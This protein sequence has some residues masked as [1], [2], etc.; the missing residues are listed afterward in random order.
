VSGDYCLELDQIIKE[1]GLR[2]AF[3][4]RNQGHIPTIE[5]M[6]EEGKTWEEIGRAIRWD[7]FTAQQHY[8]WY[9]EDEWEIAS[10]AA[11]ESPSQRPTL[12]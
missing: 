12:E 8:T 3:G 2:V 7:P 10:K 4:L 9:L 1:C 11:G 6:L 5:K